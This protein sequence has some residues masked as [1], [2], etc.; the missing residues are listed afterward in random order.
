MS[1]RVYFDSNILIEFCEGGHQTSPE[2]IRLFQMFT[3]RP[4]IAVTSLFTL[5]EVLGRQALYMEWPDQKTLYRGLIVRNTFIDVVPLDETIFLSASDLRRT[6]RVEGRNL[7]LADAI[8]VASA[9]A[10]SCEY[11][12]TA[13]VRL[14]RG[15]PAALRSVMPSRE[16]LQG[17][18]QVLDA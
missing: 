16:G 12:L 1:S 7:R 3:L 4:R 5:G 9:T 10:T 11:F 17:L 8:H 13:D 18:I 2:L 14:A 6:S 15:L